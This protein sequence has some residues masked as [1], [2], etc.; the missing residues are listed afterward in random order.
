[1]GGGSIAPGW[2]IGRAISVAY[3]RAGARVAVADLKLP[4]TRE[5]V[6]VI[7]SESGTAEAFHVDV[8]NITLIAS[9][10]SGATGR[11]GALDVL[12]NNVELSKKRPPA[13]HQRG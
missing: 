11:L 13:R 2:G 6:D 7:R 5:T 10:V 12:H 8:L 1:M 3:A 4:S 9:L